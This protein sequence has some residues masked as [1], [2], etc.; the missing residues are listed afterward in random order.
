MR[1][2]RIDAKPPLPPEPSAA[3]RGAVQLSEADKKLRMRFVGQ[4]LWRG[5]PD[6]K[7]VSFCRN[8]WGMTRRAS[9]HM[10][11]RVKLRWVAEEERNRPKAKAW[12][13]QRLLNDLSELRAGESKTWDHGA[14]MQRE[15]L[16]S[17]LQGTKEPI[18][19][20]VEFAQVEAVDRVMLELTPEQFR[21]AV[22]IA[23]DEKRKARLFE[24]GKVVA[25]QQDGTEVLT[26]PR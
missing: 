24:A 5:S 11:E 17:D 22:D 14:I 1:R 23:L 2:R 16:L 10:I 6:E 7:V 12:A 9:L 25:T 15:R 26:R 8:T 21:A 4:L 19:V 3:P 13:I 18:K 20:N